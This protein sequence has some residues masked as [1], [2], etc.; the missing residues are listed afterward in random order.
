MPDS[1]P[2][3]RPCCQGHL[4][5][6]RLTLPFLGED[7]GSHHCQIQSL[8]E[9][10]SGNEEQAPPLSTLQVY[11]GIGSQPLISLFPDKGIFCGIVP[12]FQE[13]LLRPTSDLHVLYHPFVS[14]N[15]LILFAL[16]AATLTCAS[17]FRSTLDLQW[18]PPL[19]LFQQCPQVAGILTMLDSARNQ[20]SLGYPITNTKPSALS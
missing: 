19:S 16:L 5:P 15:M 17:W 13:T 14:E 9:M 1:W 10:G 2:R 4:C 7:S 12:M 6:L 20:Y 3:S 18:S 11:P 8:C